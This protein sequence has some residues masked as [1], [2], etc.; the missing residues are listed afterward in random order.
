[1]RP[2][3]CRLWRRCRRRTARRICAALLGPPPPPPRL[4]RL[5]RLDR[6]G[7]HG[8]PRL[9]HAGTSVVE[10]GLAGGVDKVKDVV[11]V[12]GCVLVDHGLEHVAQ[13]IDDDAGLMGGDELLQ[14]QSAE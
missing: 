13:M 7:R 14:K 6:L 1:M 9:G 2:L 11:R 8:L 5:N 4:D 12:D 10:L 3:G